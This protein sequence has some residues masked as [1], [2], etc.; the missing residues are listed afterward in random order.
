[1]YTNAGSMS[2]HVILQLRF[3]LIS[4]ATKT[5]MAEAI[6]AEV[7]GPSW[8]DDS[9]SW[10]RCEALAWEAGVWIVGVR[11]GRMTAVAATM[12]L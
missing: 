2:T 1:M 10:R 11:T 8:S 5:A 12:S 4:Q 9:S 7:T 3:P 6:L